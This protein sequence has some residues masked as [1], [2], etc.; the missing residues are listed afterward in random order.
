MILVAVGASVSVSSIK[1]PHC[2]EQIFGV[3]VRYFLW[4]NNK[5]SALQ[6]NTLHQDFIPCQGEMLMQKRDTKFF[7][8]TMPLDYGLEFLK[9]GFISRG[10]LGRLRNGGK[11]IPIFGTHDF[12]LP[13]S[14]QSTRSY[15]VRNR[16]V[17][18]GLF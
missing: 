4:L 8:Q 1:S 12:T 17:K 5:T 18:V 13:D 15:S 10:E 16:A 11:I 14:Y 2:C 6:M 7:L 9:A 3:D